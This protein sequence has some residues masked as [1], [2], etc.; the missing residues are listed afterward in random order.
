[1]VLTQMVKICFSEGIVNVCDRYDTR[2]SSAQVYLCIVSLFFWASGQVPL[3]PP[4]FLS[5]FPLLVQDSQYK[6]LP[7]QWEQNA[8]LGRELK[9]TW[10]WIHLGEIG[11]IFLLD[12]NP[13]SAS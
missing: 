9:Q 3:Q 11:K 12:V 1:M 2:L 6:P 5:F 7:S 8:L 4:I 13:T 10:F